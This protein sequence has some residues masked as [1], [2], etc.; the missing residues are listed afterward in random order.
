MP[1][2][3]VSESLFQNGYIIFQ[4]NVDN[5]EIVHRTCKILVLGATP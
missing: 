1:F 5:F 4:E 3:S 2:L